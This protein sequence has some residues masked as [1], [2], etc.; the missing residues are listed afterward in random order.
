MVSRPL[1]NPPQGGAS[2][3]LGATVL[4]SCKDLEGV[5]LRY[6]QALSQNWPREAKPRKTR[7]KLACNAAEVQ[8]GRLGNTGFQRHHDAT[9]LG[10]TTN[11]RT[12]GME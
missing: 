9:R 4:Y 11:E 7:L 3:G 12:R 1:W 5:G 8:N 6:L 10:S 2:L